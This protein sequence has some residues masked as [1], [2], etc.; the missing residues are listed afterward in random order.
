MSATPSSTRAPILFLVEDDYDWTFFFCTEFQKLAPRWEIVSSRDGAEAMR[1]LSRA[2]VPRV[3]VTDLNMP[4]IGGIAL[5][6][7]IK[8][9]EPFRALPLVVLSSSEDPTHRQCCANLGI[10]SYL[11][12]PNSLNELRQNIRDIITLGDASHFDSK[13]RN[14][15]RCV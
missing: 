4:G 2:V 5:I 8:N 10:N 11:V 1:L 15:M 7:W 3:I 9:Q 12:K 6:E 14:E 13:D